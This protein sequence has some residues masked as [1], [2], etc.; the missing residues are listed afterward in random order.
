MDKKTPSVAERRVFLLG[1][2]GKKRAVLLDFLEEI[3]HFGTAVLFDFAF[4]H[5][6]GE[7]GVDGESDDVVYPKLLRRLFDAARPKN[8]QFFPAMRGASP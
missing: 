7:I 2:F 4:V 1:L 6:T 8:V 5:Q 3:V